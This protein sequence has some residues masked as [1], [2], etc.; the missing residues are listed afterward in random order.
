ML[1]SSSRVLMTTDRSFSLTYT[2]QMWNINMLCTASLF[3]IQGEHTSC[4]FRQHRLTLREHL[5][6][7]GTSTINIL[8][9]TNVCQGVIYFRPLN[10]FACNISTNFLVASAL[11]GINSLTAKLVS[12][13]NADTGFFC[14]AELSRWKERSF[15][16]LREF[17]KL[18]QM[19]LNYTT[20]SGWLCLLHFTR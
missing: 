3:A 2:G 14:L 6:S 13:Q 18:L 20:V 1:N 10:T 12:G 16:I 9:D 19:S 11:S 15:D 4:R 7:T 17:E 8:A 5:S